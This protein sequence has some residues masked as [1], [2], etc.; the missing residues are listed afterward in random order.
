MRSINPPPSNIIMGQDYYIGKGA[1]VTPSYIDRLA[2]LQSLSECVRK[3][4]VTGNLI[5]E[6]YRLEAGLERLSSLLRKCHQKGG[7]VIFIGNGGSAAIA[8]HMSVDYSKNK[9]IRAVSFSANTAMMT[10]LANDYGYEQVFAK[11]IEY[12]GRPEDVVV[13]ISS[14]GKSP[15]ILA[16]ASQA[17]ESDLAARVTLSGMNP[18]NSLRK[19]GNLNFYIP[20]TDYGLVELAHLALLHS[21][22]SCQ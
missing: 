16:A 12:Y 1:F 9:G 21:V 6:V 5:D 19:R 11:Q 14:S 3:T 8:S 7:K 13:I 17:V 2:W 20:C 22:A 15:N 18:N 10:C 4:S